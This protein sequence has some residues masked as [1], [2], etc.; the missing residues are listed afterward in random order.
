MTSEKKEVFEKPIRLVWE[1]PSELPVNY[2]NHIQITHAGGNEF[3]IFFGYLAP[4]LTHGLTKEEIANLPEKLSIT[5]LTNIIVTPEFMK[6][7]VE[8]FEENLE[9][10]RNTYESR[11]E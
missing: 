9:N 5:P 4:L 11:D 10:Y 8:I 2:S 7:I 3:H 6:T 1:S